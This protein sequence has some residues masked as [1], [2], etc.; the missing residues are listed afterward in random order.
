[1]TM[2]CSE[3]MQYNLMLQFP[4]WLM[5][6][7]YLKSRQLELDLVFEMYDIVCLSCYGFFTRSL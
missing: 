1:M 6:H 5:P 2:F 4:C 3:G 7:S